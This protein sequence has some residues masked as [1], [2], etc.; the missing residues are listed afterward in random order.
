MH[1]AQVVGAV[2]QVMWCRT[3]ELALKNIS[4][5]SSGLKDWHKRLVMDLAE[6][7]ALIRS[8]LTPL[9]RSAIVALVTT[10][11]HSRDIG[12]C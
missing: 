9:Q 1:H 4:I 6:L 3:T 2:S 7:T 12:A 11:V 5:T 8:D 10:D